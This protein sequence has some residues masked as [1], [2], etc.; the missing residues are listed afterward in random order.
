MNKLRKLTKAIGRI[1]R[2]PY[3]LNLVLQDEGAA[4]EE[5]L[6]RY[7]CPD[8]LPL[9]ELSTLFPDF[10]EKVFPYAYLSGATMPI[11]IALLKALAAKYGAKDYFEIGTWRGE[12]V[13]N[14]AEVVPHC[15]TFNL[16]KERIVAL[17]HNPDYAGLHGF[18]SQSKAGVEQVYGDS[19]T[20]DFTPHEGKFDL[21]FVDGDHHRESVLKDTR[22]AFRLR[23]DE[24]SIIVWHDYAYD[25]ES[26]RW[27]VLSAI[28]EGTPP[29]MR[30]R[31]YH[32]AHTL[33]AVYLPESLGT[34]ET[35]KLSP[36]EAPRQCFEVALRAH[37]C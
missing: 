18:F 17:T 8:G 16:P 36:Y 28:L 23:R 7:A 37:D 35:H 12:S 1:C 22:T 4:K 5:T 19:Q 9:V 11:D 27:N 2:H 29:E 3:L 13:A 20:F 30:G 34:F 26:I 21:I 15:V 6:R 10:Q 32:V 31:L 14:V 24:R 33:C 25:P